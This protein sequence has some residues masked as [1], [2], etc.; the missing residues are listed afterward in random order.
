MPDAT[1]LLIRAYIAKIDSLN[2]G[3][4]VW[5]KYVPS[6][7]DDDCYIQVGAV[8]GNDEPGKRIRLE[9]YTIAVSIFSRSTEIDVDILA[10]TIRD[11]ICD[12][13]RN[14]LIDILPLKTFIVH[15][16]SAS[17]DAIQF[18]DKI[19]INRHWVFTHKVVT[20]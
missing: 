20:S 17:P 8:N 13:H 18:P 12:E 3:Y 2:T 19:L 11:A 4:T 16:S 1:D 6:T 15:V 9:Q 7:I 14:C 10:G 5:G